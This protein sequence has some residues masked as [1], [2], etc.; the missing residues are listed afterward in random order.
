MRSAEYLTGAWCQQ[1]GTMNGLPFEAFYERTHPDTLR[2]ATA[3]VGVLDAEDVCQDA[4]LR[5][6]RAWGTA[7][8]ER[9]D[10]WV[11]R[12]VRNACVDRFR[13]LHRRGDAEAGIAS[14]VDPVSVEEVVAQ[15]ASESSAKRAMARLSPLLRETLWLRE[16]MGLTYAEIAEVQD[17]PVGTVMSRLHSARRKAARSLRA[18]GL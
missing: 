7:E 3:V 13:A 15:R 6:W 16:M 17:I 10:A 9:L 4:W 12:I 11:F 8:P 2:Y 18:E 1:S 5:V 14:L